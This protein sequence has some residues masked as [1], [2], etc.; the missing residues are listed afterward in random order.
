MQDLNEMRMSL[1]ECN[2]VFETLSN[3]NGGDIA[4]YSS[5]EINELRESIENMITAWIH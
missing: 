1:A 3:E 4:T 2:N 5:S